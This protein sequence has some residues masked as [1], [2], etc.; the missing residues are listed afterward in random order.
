MTGIDDEI[1]RR[2]AVEQD[3][4]EN[5]ARSARE[6]NERSQAVW[7][8]AQEPIHD[9]LTRMRPIQNRGARRWRVVKPPVPSTLEYQFPVA[10]KARKVT[11]WAVFTLVCDD[12]VS[13]ARH[14]VVTI[15]GDIYVPVVHPGSGDRQGGWRRTNGTPGEVTIN[16]WHIREALEDTTGLVR[17]LAEVVLRHSSG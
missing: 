16:A 12:G 10:K 3:H 11:G 2:R 14:I 17:A 1:E 13:A 15:D 4:Q 9:F 7:L 6:R 5:L 8:A